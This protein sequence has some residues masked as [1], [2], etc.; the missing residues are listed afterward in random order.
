DEESDGKFGKVINSFRR[1]L[2][3]YQFYFSRI[4]EPRNIRVIVV[5]PHYIDISPEAIDKF[6]KVYKC[7]LWK[8][9]IN[10]ETT[11]V[12]VVPEYLRGRMSKDFEESIEISD[13]MGRTIREIS[14]KLGKDEATLKEIVK[15]KSEDFSVFFEQYVMDA[16]DAIAEIKPGQIGE[17]YID[18]KLIDLVFKLE[19][20][21]YSG[22]LRK[23]VNEHLDEKEDDYLFSRKCFNSLWKS[24]FDETYPKMLEQFE[25]FLQQ[26][27]PRYRDHFI[28]QLQDFLLGTII[29]DHLLQKPERWLG[30]LKIDI[31][32]ENLAKGWLLASSIHD[33][34]YPL[35]KY[36]EW[37][38]GFFKEQLKIDEPLSF[39]ELKGIYVEKSFLTRV[40]HLLSIIGESFVN[41]LERED[42]TILYNEI[43]RFFYYEIS[44]KKNHGLMSA[45]Y[46]LKKF[47]EKG[48]DLSNIILPASVASAIHDDEIWQILS[49]QVNGGIEKKWEYIAAVLDIVEK[50]IVATILKNVDFDDE[51]KE[52]EIAKTLRREKEWIGNM[53]A[54]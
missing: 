47:E 26:F 53:Y 13:D 51:Q 8:I 46:L 41:R 22:E 33:F 36:D 24:N 21:S 6:F 9:D 29:L 38:S 39:L 28:H 3:F 27:F 31:K 12:I 45:S 40:E 4:A 2:L 1:R 30:N 16:V 49:G 14:E 5:L 11:D 54:D 32:K 42:K 43:R 34:T 19:K 52:R 18:R 50:N 20:V 44:E 48:E 7:G 23:L 25:L 17:R 35:Q 37:S 15:E 10:M